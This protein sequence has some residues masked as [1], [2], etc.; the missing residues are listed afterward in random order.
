LTFY[1]AE[2]EAKKIDVVAVVTDNGRNILRAVHIG[3]YN[4]ISCLGKDC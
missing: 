3:G 1:C 4:S 2:G